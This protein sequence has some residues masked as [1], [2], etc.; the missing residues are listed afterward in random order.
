MKRDP[1]IRE[2]V[3]SEINYDPFLK[4]CKIVVDVSDGKVTLS[5]SVSSLAQKIH[6]EK[7]AGRVYGVRAIAED[8][9]VDL[10]PC[11]YRSDADIAHSVDNVLAWN[12]AV[13]QEGITVKVENG[14]VSLEGHVDW[15][16]QRNAAARSITSLTGVRNV[17]NLIKV[18][19]KVSITDVRS[20]I[21]SA[22]HRSATINAERIAVFVDGSRVTLQG[23]V[24]SHSARKDAEEAAWKASGVTHVDS[25][26]EVD[27]VGIALP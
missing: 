23:R 13:P 17:N 27:V 6:A 20:E 10:N 9:T 12:S 25:Y 4:G 7:A 8:I 2:D 1:G 16:F 26:I 21:S 24:S 15:E 18:T 3:I 22:L 11:S 14:I 19:P 5:G